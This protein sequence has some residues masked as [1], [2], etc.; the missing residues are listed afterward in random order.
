MPR[1]VR[2]TR[3][4]KNDNYLGNDPASATIKHRPVDPVE[5]ERFSTTL[6]NI[7]PQDR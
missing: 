7:S 5:H 3:N 2:P 4:W 1:P 6:R